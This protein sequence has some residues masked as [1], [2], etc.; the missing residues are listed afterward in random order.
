MTP[1]DPAL[2]QHL[3][4]A[5]RPLVGVLAAALLG[6]L[7]T[8]AQAF[9]LG[10]LLVRLVEGG[11][12]SGSAWWL[13]GLTLGRALTAYAVDACSAAAAGRVSQHLRGLL[14]TR[15]LSW[16]AQTLRGHRTGELTVLCTRGMVAIEPYLTRYLPTLVL[17]AV[18][19]VTTVVAIWWLDWL[20]GL[21]VV[22]TL[23]LVPLF[24]V[25]IGMATRDRAD[26]QWRQLTVLS[27]H[28][29]DVVR[30]LP[31]L[32]AYRRADAQA[33]SIRRITA[34]YRKATLDTL[35][36][37]F[38]SSAALELV[39]TISV[40]F[41]AVNVGLRLAGGS[42]DFWTAMVVLLLAPE[43]Y[44]P[45]RRV[46]A[47]F[48]AAAEGTAAF[49][50]ASR[51]LAVDPRTSRAGSAIRASS[52]VVEGVSGPAPLQLC[53]LTLTYP[54][55]AAPV[56]AGLDAIVPATGLTT[57]TGPSG[58]GKS[59]LLAALLGE[60]APCGGS[61]RVGT[62]DLA[63]LDESAW[64]SQVAW[65]PQRPWLTAGSIADNLRHGRP[66]ATDDELWTALGRVALVDVVAALPGGL[67]AV[68][69][70]DGAGLSA[71]QRAR[72][73][74][75]RVVVSERPFVVLDE[76][77]A[78]LDAL[79]ED[80]LLRTLRD[81]ARDRSVVV[82]AHR[83]AVIEAADT[84]IELPAARLAA[85]APNQVPVAPTAPPMADIEAD[86][87]PPPA[88]WGAR[89][90]IALGALSVASGVA[91]TA[92][93]SWLIT[94]ASFRPPVLVLMV[95]IVGVRTFGLA[96]PAL[97]YAE[98]L[99]SHDAALTLL[100][101]R[102]AQV[103]DALVPLVPGRLGLHRGDLLTSVVDDVDAFVDERLRVRE[104]LWTAV[105]VGMGATLLALVLSPV[106]GGIV[107][108]VCG[109]GLLA[110][111]IARWGVTAAEP[112]F[113]AARAC[114]STRV[115]EILGSARDLVL[116]GSA[117]GALAG[118]DRAA[119]ALDR[120]TARSARGVAAAR[121]LPVVAGGL[122]PIGV[123]AWVPRSDTSL[124][125][126]ALLVLLPIALVEAFTPLAEAGA[127]GVR[128]RA[129]RVRLAA[130]EGTPPAVVDTG[131]TPL[132]ATG[133]V[134]PVALA[135]VSAGW[136]DDDVVDG[137]DLDLP[138][139]SRVGIVGP[140]G[141]G[142]STLAAVLL[143]FL[144]V[145][146]GS[147]HLADVDVRDLPLDDVRRTVGLVDDDPYVFGSTVAENVRLARPDAGDADVLGALARAHLAGWVAGLPD[148]V[149]TFIGE[150]HA[151]VSGGERARLGLARAMLA[152]APVLVLDEPTAHL[153][154]GTAQTVADDMLGGADGRTIVWITHTTVG[155]DQ[156]QRIVR[157]DG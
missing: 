62:V 81:L 118:L 122:A 61:V 132:P 150:G 77:T 28:F 128:T 17:A 142:K 89:T 115:E 120:S 136:G 30:G 78:H 26:R 29:L 55:R 155:L 123:A 35:R 139:G 56:V 96:R 145:R 2:G 42:L 13:A 14:L 124:P 152:E 156:M 137:L 25:L 57:I 46:G 38:A 39:A 138:P 59:T 108:G 6:G 94:S 67:E 68:L 130:L 19:P 84:V 117:P 74:L 131:T 76:P 48:H 79:T 97:R 34:R 63:D 129:A 21:I 15:A 105:L 109:L 127:L 12:W 88:R 49:A 31:T 71:G 91:L 72:L 64:R 66:H 37:A 85:P 23:P 135:D 8:L 100:A 1:L 99:V 53:N 36:I 93:A 16:D 144:D 75:A 103:Y 102:R 3:W 45:L 51:L 111:P 110:F 92:T 125:M 104:P 141:C 116:W 107:A 126:L 112:A 134:P 101:E 106:A 119:A 5:R 82:V 24:A 83:P 47:E 151:A 80:T 86:E 33:A 98:R 70:E 27:G 10:T 22:L 44:W 4:P 146:A 7:L 95:A 157:L 50:Q 121:L 149:H 69:G 153:D 40:A 43:A 114:V 18:L 140:S 154:S 41:V 90:G 143:R 65:A 148:G 54:G 58:C 133:E 52:P 73:A 147:V 32:V 113:V 87:V 60:L 20:S 11:D 9:A